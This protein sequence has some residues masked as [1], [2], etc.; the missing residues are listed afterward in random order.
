MLAILAIVICLLEF[1]YFFKS[2][3]EGACPLRYASKRL[4]CCCALLAR[5]VPRSII[6]E[7]GPAHVI[8]L[9]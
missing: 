9:I 1:P 8:S 7:L 3:R 4:Y 6:V 2:Y 5:N